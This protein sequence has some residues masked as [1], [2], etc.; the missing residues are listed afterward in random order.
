MSMSCFSVIDS[1]NK[2]VDQINM[3]L[4]D[5]MTDKHMQYHYACIK[6]NITFDTYYNNLKERWEKIMN[7]FLKH[8]NICGTGLS[9]LMTLYKYANPKNIEHIKNIIKSFES[10]A[11]EGFSPLKLQEIDIDKLVLDVIA[12]SLIKTDTKNDFHVEPKFIDTITNLSKILIDNCKCQLVDIYKFLIKK[13]KSKYQKMF[14]GKTKNEIIEL[15]RLNYNKFKEIVE[16]ISKTNSR[17]LVSDVVSDVSVKMSSLYGFSV[18]SEL[19]KLIPADLGS[20]KYFFIKV[21][22]TYYNELHPIIWAQ[23]FKGIANNIFIELPVT[24]KD[25]FAFASEQ[26]LLNSGPFIL[27]ILQMIRPFLSPEIAAKYKLTKLTYPKLTNDQVNLMLNKVVYNWNMYRILESFSASVGHVSK[28]V[29]TDN[30]DKPFMIKMIKPLAIAQS[31]WEYSILHK[32]FKEGSCEQTFIKNIMESNGL[33]LNVLNEI[34]NIKKGHEYYNENYSNIFPVNIDAKLTTIENIPGVIQFDCWYALTMTIAPGVPLSKL[35]EKDELKKDTSYR[36]RL[37]R[38]LDL[39]VFKF[40]QNL[41]QNGYYHGDL[42]AGNIFFSFD[43]KQLTLI[44]FGAVGQINIFENTSDINALLDIIVMSIFQNFDEMLDAMS[45]LLNSKCIETQIDMNSAEYQKIKNELYNYKIQ[46]I[47]NEQREAEKEKI[48][49]R[50]IFSEKRIA[51]ENMRLSEYKENVFN[52]ENAESIY[53]YLEFEPSKSETVVENKDV[54]PVFTEIIGDSDS[55]TFAGILE[56]IIKF[57]ATTGVNIAIKFNEFYEFQKAYALLLGVLH[58]TGYSSYR[59]NIAIRKAFV[60][61]KNLNKFYHVQTISH[62]L[63]TYRKEREKYRAIKKELQQAHKEIMRT[64]HIK[65]PHKK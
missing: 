28:V 65:I 45:V 63:K 53:S 57:Y 36:A 56:K 49:D 2:T 64:E 31:C 46:N 58:K 7:D 8:P 9:E 1:L 6:P 43:K 21:I 34:E 54:L 52:P 40:F 44:D 50:D 42:H 59:A 13:Y 23:I 26:L 17:K 29:R 4:I 3:E 32:I 14:A 47:I 30:P 33:E 60:S 12:T 24:Q 16:Q 41:I 37:H 10:T 61:W 20:L 27:K 18:E 15:L 62:F 51:D 48:Y 35:V 11:E 5:N 25:F 55:I 38:C 19:D 39:L 22:S